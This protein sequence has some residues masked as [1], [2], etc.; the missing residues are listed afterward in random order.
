MLIGSDGFG[1]ARDGKRRIYK[2]RTKYKVIVKDNVEIGANTTIVAPIVAL[3]I[4]VFAPISTLSLTMTLP[5]CAIFVYAPF[6]S[7]ANPKPSLPIT[8]PA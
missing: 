3:S 7:G 6:A 1:F 8:A 4:V 5:I 2:N